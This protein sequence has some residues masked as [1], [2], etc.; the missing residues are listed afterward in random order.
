MRIPNSEP[1][2]ASRFSKSKMSSGALRISPGATQSFFSL[3]YDPE[4]GGVLWIYLAIAWRRVFR[5]RLG[6]IDAMPMRKEVQGVRDVRP[7]CT[8]LRSSDRGCRIR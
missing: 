8:G 1:P 7:A 4:V 5:V 3:T 6:S 2:I